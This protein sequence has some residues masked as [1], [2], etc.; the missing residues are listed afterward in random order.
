MPRWRSWSAHCGLELRALEG[1]HP[2]S[3]QVCGLVEIYAHGEVRAAVADL[4]ASRTVTTSASRE[5]IG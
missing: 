2:D 4:V 3:E 5:M 1:V